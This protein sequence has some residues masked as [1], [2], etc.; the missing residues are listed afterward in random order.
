MNDGSVFVIF[1]VPEVITIT[2][3]MGAFFRGPHTDESKQ[4]KQRDFNFDCVE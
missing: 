3:K 1:Q 2:F 4:I